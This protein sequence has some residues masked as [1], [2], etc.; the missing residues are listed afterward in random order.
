MQTRRVE[1]VTAIA[2]WTRSPVTT[3]LGASTL[4]ELAPGRYRFGLGAIPPSWSQDWHGLDGSHPVERMRDFVAA[5]RAAWTSGPGRPAAH[6]GPFYSF[7]DYERPT[8]PAHGPI[9]LYLAGNRPRMIELA[10][11]VA[12]GAIFAFLHSAEWLRE[13]GLPT[14]ERG[15]ARAGRSRSSFDVGH[16]VFCAVAGS[17]AEAYDLLRPGLAFHFPRF[18]DI[19]ADHGFADEL[20]GAVSDRAVEAMCIAGTPQQVRDKLRR[21]EGIVDWPCLMPP[22]GLPPAVSR[23]QVRRII[24]AF[25]QPAAAVAPAAPAAAQAP[26]A[27]AS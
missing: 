2:N 20:H 14:V 10:G 24:D 7:R 4:A 17:E 15:L 6:E 21:Y 23:E 25:R 18:R 3:A 19:L 5:V 27:P 1:L 11:E 26:P 12:D 9:P 13:V 16:I 8:E 22:L